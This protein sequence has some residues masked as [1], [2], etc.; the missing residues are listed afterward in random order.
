MH[1]RV[2]PSALSILS[3]ARSSL[4]SELALAKDKARISAEEAKKL[5]YLA[6]PARALPSMF[7][8]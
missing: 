8:P 2:P 3:Q 4:E 7:D 1:A 5:R 6:P